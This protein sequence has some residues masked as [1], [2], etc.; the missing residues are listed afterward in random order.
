MLKIWGLISKSHPVCLPNLYSPVRPNSVLAQGRTMD[1]DSASDICWL[2][3]KAILT[4]HFVAVTQ[5]LNIDS[6]PFCKTSWCLISNLCSPVNSNWTFQFTWLLFCNP[7]RIFFVSLPTQP[8]WILFCHWDIMCLS[9]SRL[10]PWSIIFDRD[11][12]GIPICHGYPN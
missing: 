12:T 3:I 11:L 9:T 8:F 5:T 4:A 1:G 6:G 10:F 7:A 2:K